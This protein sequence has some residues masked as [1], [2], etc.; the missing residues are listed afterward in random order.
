MRAD[1][2]PA[3]ARWHRG[4]PGAADAAGS[5]SHAGVPL[6]SS[7]SAALAVRSGSEAQAQASGASAA[8]A[9][10]PVPGLQP[11]RPG[12]ITAGES[13]PGPGLQPADMRG[14]VGTG[15]TRDASG[16]PSGKLADAEPSGCQSAPL[17]S[18]A[19][20]SVAVVPDP[21]PD[22][23]SAGP[24]LQAAMPRRQAASIG[25]SR[26]V[27]RPAPVNPTHDSGGLSS[28]PGPASRAADTGAVSA[29]CGS[30]SGAP[31]VL[32]SS[33]APGLLRSEPNGAAAEGGTLGASAPLCGADAALAE[34]ACGSQSAEASHMQRTVSGSPECNQGGLELPNLAGLVSVA[35]SGEYVT[36]SFDDM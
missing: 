28:A 31:A 14:S 1:R 22:H 30:S 34:S 29:A 20:L 9:A 33:T 32:A 27:A 11:R 18:S 16:A 26:P 6:G 19:A 23:D 21:N 25:V 5:A 24:R 8:R 17:P 35:T 15:P 7:A 12:G 4:A 2:Q 10:A 13:Q 3:G 36:F